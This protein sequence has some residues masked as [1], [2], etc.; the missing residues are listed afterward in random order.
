MRHRCLQ[1]KKIMQSCCKRPN[2][3]SAHLDRGRIRCE[4]LKSFLFHLSYVSRFCHAALA[5]PSRNSTTARA[6]QESK[7][8][9]SI[10]EHSWSDR[11]VNAGYL[12]IMANLSSVLCVRISCGR[13][14]EDQMPHWSMYINQ[15]KVLGFS[16]IVAWNCRAVRKKAYFSRYLLVQGLRPARDASKRRATL[17]EKL[18]LLATDSM[19]NNNLSAKFDSLIKYNN[20]IGCQFVGR[21]GNTQSR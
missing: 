13:Q 12:R 21:S 19:P 3:F 16:E 18:I 2:A 8:F 1:N 15:G 5:Y 17:C 11:K 20:A 14:D 7:L 4:A 6:S 9:A 10:C